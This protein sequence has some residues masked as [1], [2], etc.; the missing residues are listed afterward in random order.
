MT[1]AGSSE[2]VTEET[3]LYA[4]VFASVATIP[5]AVLSEH[6][7]ILPIAR[8]IAATLKRVRFIVVAC[9]SGDALQSGRRSFRG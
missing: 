4:S 6:E 9:A 1:E 8:P 7:T 5:V 3:L 2:T